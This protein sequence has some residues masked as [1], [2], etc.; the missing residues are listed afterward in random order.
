MSTHSN[1]K[2]ADPTTKI[3]VVILNG[4]LGSGKTTMLRSL[5]VQSSKKKLSVCVIVNDMSE[6]DVD[7]EL[8]ANTDIVGKGDHNFE[9]IHSCVLS[10]KKGIEKLHEALTGMLAKQQPDL[11]L[12]ETSGSCHPMPLVQYFKAKSNFKLTGVLTLADSVMIAQDYEYGRQL[13]PQMKYNVQHQKRDTTNL[14][15]EQIM[16]SSHLI[17]TKGDRVGDEGLQRIA[18]SMQPL[19]P[20]VN[21]FSVLWGNLSIDDVLAMPEYNY[22]RVGQ[23]IEELIP[24]L[25]LES[26][27]ERPYNLATRVIKDERPFHPQ[28]LWETCH[29]YLDQRIYRSKG[30]F[31]LATRDKISLLWNQAAGSINLELVGYWR[32]GV[33][34][35]EDSGLLEMEIRI[36]KERLAKESGRF[37]DRHCHLTVIGD[38][39]QVDSFTEALRSCFLT[40]EEIQYWQAGGEFPDP[41]PNNMVKLSN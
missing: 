28:R 31:W 32:S 6:L 37:G 12:I 1:Q 7:G 29:Q 34:E 39:G 30:F 38:K 25:E 40:E 11:V 14:L 9:S 5:L 26:H 22:F 41:W 3:P 24:V 33:V 23:L 10:S 18:K 2:S 27:D 19:N 13:V 35:E 36:L 16:F 4:F 21:V 8:I 17:L 20:Y 15:V